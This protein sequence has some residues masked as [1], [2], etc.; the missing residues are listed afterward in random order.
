MSWQPVG[1]TIVWLLSVSLVLSCGR[2][3][4]LERVSTTVS[5]RVFDAQTMAGV[6]GAV[7]TTEPISAQVSTNNDGQYWLET[8]VVVGQSY[9][10]HANK[11]G[12]QQ[13][14]TTVEVAEGRNTS[15]DIPLSKSGPILQV[16][17]TTLQFGGTRDR[18][19]F[20]VSNAGS[21]ALNYAISSPTADWLSIEAATE[22]TVTDTSKTVTLRANRTG[23]TTGSYTTE[24]R[25]NSN[26][27]DAAISVSLEVLGPN[28]PRLSV[29]P[30]SLSFGTEA[31]SQSLTIENI[32]TGLL[33]WQVFASQGW[34]RVSP[35]S[36]E[37]TGERDTVA[38]TIDRSGLSDGEHAGSLSIRTNH[39]DDTIPISVAVTGGNTN[40][41]PT[42]NFVG[43]SI[44]SR[45]N[46]P[47]NT[48]SG[49]AY[50]GTSLWVGDRTTQQ[51]YKL[52]P[53][54][55]NVR[56]TYP[57]PANGLVAMTFAQGSLILAFQDKSVYRVAP[58]TGSGNA[59][60][61]SL[62]IKGLAYDGTHMITWE[63]SSLKRRE[64]ATFSPIYVTSIS[65]GNNGL[66]YSEGN[67]FVADTP[68]TNGSRFSVSVKVLDATRLSNAELKRQINLPLDAS[69]IT[70]L[71]A[72]G[73]ILWVLGDG[74]G[75][76][77]DKI[78]RVELQ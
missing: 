11:L 32:G 63:D 72:H 14:S 22:G 1:Q 66:A 56:A 17:T 55:G 75:S 76:D 35:S 13:N 45:I 52:D 49:L 65:T 42:T 9:R 28:Q 62:T 29:A 38:V 7:V 26:G 27:G 39:I 41:Q 16:D 74:Y 4:D 33:T 12:F 25:V 15:V 23:L 57:L 20:V 37:T 36:G 67:F 21:G 19:Q 51:L 54:N 6:A 68:T 60:T 53:I 59:Y 31:Q 46:T 71:A 73:N 47:G 2:P 69:I 43:G 3:E 44:T 64:P 77:A 40:T 8:N 50:D 48:P 78:S 70:G 58:D 61:Q 5:G 24:V 34:I 18:T 10:V 30:R